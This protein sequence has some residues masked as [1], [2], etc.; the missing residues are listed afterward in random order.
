MAEAKSVLCDRCSFFQT[1]N[2]GF[3]HSVTR[4]GTSE[5]AALVLSPVLFSFTSFFAWCVSI[6]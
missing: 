2:V 4:C 1:L 5:T 6:I 3:N